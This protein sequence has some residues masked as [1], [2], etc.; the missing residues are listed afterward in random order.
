LAFTYAGVTVGG[1]VLWGSF[2]NQVQLKPDGVGS[3]NAVAWVGGAQYAIGPWTFDASYYNY[4]YQGALIGGK[5]LSQ[6]YDDAF[7][8]G[9]Q[10]AVAPGMTG[11]AEYLYGQ[12]HQGGV[13]L[14]TA[15]ASA[16][17]NNTHTQGLIIGTRVQW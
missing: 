1:N 15:G 12:A 5:N 16:L 7:A 17:L 10:Y 14:F 9:I 2:N 6:R 3:P 8:A 11:Y 13:N 4:Q